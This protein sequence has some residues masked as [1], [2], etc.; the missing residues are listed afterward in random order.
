MGNA[1]SPCCR[2]PDGSRSQVKLVFWEGT[3]RA[4][5]GKHVA[6]EIMFEFPDKMVCHAGSFFLGRPIPALAIEDD[7]MPGETYFVLPLDCFP[8]GG[9]RTLSA[10]SLAALGSASPR[11]GPMSF[12]EGGGPFEYIK[13]KD[14]RV[15]IKVVP[16]FITR[17]IMKGK[18]VDDAEGN[19]SSSVSPCRGT[20]CSTPELQ[21][22]YQQLVGAREQVWSPKLETI[23]EHRIRYSPCR[24]MG[25]E[26]TQREMEG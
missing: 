16:E 14:G 25:L 2:H 23:S 8:G 5:T 15:L 13:S 9:A 24:F 3:T 21:K 19:N 10:S 11:P 6:G 1:V 4:L 22:Q 17:L 26:W 7:L 12:S 20:L 18:G